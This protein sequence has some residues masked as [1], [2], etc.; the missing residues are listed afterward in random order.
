MFHLKWNDCD[1]FVPIILIGGLRLILIKQTKAM[2]LKH[3]I[4]KLPTNLLTP[5]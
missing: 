4:I 2:N 5:E 3:V 1:H